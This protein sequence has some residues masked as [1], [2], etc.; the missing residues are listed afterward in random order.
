MNFKILTLISQL[1]TYGLF[2][3]GG[4]SEDSA[5][6]SFPGVVSVESLDSLQQ[7]LHLGGDTP[8]L[9]IQVIL[10]MDHVLKITVLVHH[11]HGK[12]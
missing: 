12:E 9:N 10:S 7:L 5:G 2:T 8:E 6:V 3:G 4:R 1:F 11:Y